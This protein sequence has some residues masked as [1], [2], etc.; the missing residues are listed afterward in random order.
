[1]K[2]VEGKPTQGFYITAPKMLETLAKEFPADP[3]V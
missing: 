2:G 1:M 3:L